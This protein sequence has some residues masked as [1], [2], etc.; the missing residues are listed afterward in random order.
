MRFSMFIFLLV[1]ATLYGSINLYVGVRGWQAFG[2]WLPAGSGRVYTILLLFFAF[3][4]FVGHFSGGVLPAPIQHGFSLI[5]AYWLGAITYF[6]LILAVIDLLRLLNHLT[7]LVPAYPAQ[8]PAYLGVL[9]VA[10]VTALLAYGSWNARHPR[11]RHYDITLAKAGGSPNMLHLVMISDLHLGTIV[12]R[13]RLAAMVE[14]I[15]ALH[16]DLVVLPGDIVDGEVGPYLEQGMPEIFRRLHPQYGMYGCMGN[17][18]YL[19]GQSEQ[20]IQALEDS[21]ITMLRD[22]HADIAGGFYLVGREYGG[23]RQ[24]A[25]RT[26]KALAEVLQEIDRTRPIIVLDHQPSHLAESESQGV[27]LQLSGHTHHGQFFPLNL[28]TQ[29]IFEQDWGYLRKGPYQLIV[30]CGYGTWGP[31]IRIGNTPEIVDITL[32]FGR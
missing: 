8:L 5:G 17:H 29:R 21:G 2:R 22:Q 15:E 10:L 16:P 23:E 13:D 25:G 32:H 26:R 9:V 11:I 3:S 20:I 24:H 19:G 27:G 7:G 4:F 18:E 6:L 1:F 28:V 30:S 14:R 12:D 31:P